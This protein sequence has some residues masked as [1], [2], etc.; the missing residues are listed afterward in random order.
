M[1]KLPG[2][3]NS[4]AMFPLVL[5]LMITHDGERRNERR[6]YSTGEAYLARYALQSVQEMTTRRKPTHRLYCLE[7]RVKLLIVNSGELS[8]LFPHSPS[9]CPSSKHPHGRQQSLNNHNKSDMYATRL[10][11][12]SLK[13]FHTIRSDTWRF[14]SRTT[15]T[16]R[17]SARITQAAPKQ[18][19]KSDGRG[20]G[21]LI[22][23]PGLQQ[24]FWCWGGSDGGTSLWPIR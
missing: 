11:L 16:R 1:F 24:M 3:L 22:F 9:N 21:C 17:L 18:R 10:K 12:L 6:T 5:M 20:R 23:D 14:W 4:A 2:M 13:D 19:C 15:R 7:Q 8:R